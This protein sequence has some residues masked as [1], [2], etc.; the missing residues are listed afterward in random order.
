MPSMHNRKI[1]NARTHY[2]N[3]MWSEL[4]RYTKTQHNQMFVFTSPIRLDDDYSVTGL[5]VASNANEIVYA[6]VKNRS[7]GEEFEEDIREYTIHEL[8]NIVYTIW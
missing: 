1:R 6:L 4:Q 8:E 2:Y 3:V 7:T 5:R